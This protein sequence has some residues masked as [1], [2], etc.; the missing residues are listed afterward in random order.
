MP[1][2]NPAGR[3]AVGERVPTAAAADPGGLTGIVLDAMDSLGA[4]GV[5][6]A[7]LLETVIP[8]IPSEV[9]LPV[10]GFLAQ[11][12][13]M[14]VVAVFLAA[15]LGSLAGAALL[16]QL[17]RWLGPERSRTA[18]GRLPLVDVEDV[19]R[20]FAWFTRHGRAAVLVG[21]LVPVV[22]SFVSVPA[23]V[24]RMPWP[25]FLLYTAVGSALWNGALI[26]AGMALGTQYDLVESYV[27]YLDYALVAAVVGAV[28]WAVVRHARRRRSTLGR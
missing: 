13:R 23:G 17:G 28:G 16:Y 24:V 4:L 8:P 18:L 26:G 21:R 7:I 5:G 14:N 11:T 6:L 19:E 1:G 22:R 12:G 10:A 2:R 15:T 27:G 20:T 25:Q 9:V 3:P